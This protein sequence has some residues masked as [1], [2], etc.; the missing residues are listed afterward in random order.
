MAELE[1]LNKQE[2]KASEVSKYL[3]VEGMLQHTLS[4]SEKSGDL[5]LQGNISLGRNQSYLTSK[6]NE[7]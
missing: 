6:L 2:V 7:P 5:F 3:N 4:P 1:T